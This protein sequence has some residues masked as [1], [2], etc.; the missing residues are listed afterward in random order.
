MSNSHSYN[1]R[2]YQPRVVNYDTDS[3]RTASSGRSRRVLHGAVGLILL[4]AVAVSFHW[5]STVSN[6]NRNNHVTEQELLSSLELW[7]HSHEHH[8]H[9]H[10]KHSD[11]HH[12]M[13]MEHLH[14]LHTTQAIAGLQLPGYPSPL[15]QLQYE[16][17][18]QEMDW[19]SVKKDIIHV[20]THSQDDYWPADYGTYGG[21]FIRLA[22]HSCGSYRMSDGRGGCDGGA[23][24]YVTSCFTR[25]NPI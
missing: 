22:W 8:S 16:H 25:D 14:E 6:N 7:G 3:D 19:D 4:L 5:S 13:I 20:M 15:L 24:R 1:S 17:A 18:L 23:Q 11:H 2:Q 12:S 10:G 9:S 21:L